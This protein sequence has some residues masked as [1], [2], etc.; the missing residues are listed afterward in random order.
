MNVDLAFLCVYSVSEANAKGSVIIFSVVISFLQHNVIMW[1]PRSHWGS[2]SR[3][4][5]FEID[6]RLGW[7]CDSI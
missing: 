7:A 6:S 3:A 5:G 2:V 1:I 4:C